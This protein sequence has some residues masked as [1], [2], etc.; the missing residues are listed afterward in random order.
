MNIYNLLT[1]TVAAQL[2]QHPG[3]TDENAI[4]NSCNRTL[5]QFC[6]VICF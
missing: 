4:R 1:R 5:S 6:T 2:C 3:S